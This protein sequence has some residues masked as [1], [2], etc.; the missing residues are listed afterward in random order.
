MELFNYLLN[1]FGVLSLTSD[2]SLVDILTYMFTVFGA[3]FIFTFILRSLFL[4][5]R[6]G[7]K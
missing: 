1:Y 6:F 7:E 2:A 5:L 4:L 3:L